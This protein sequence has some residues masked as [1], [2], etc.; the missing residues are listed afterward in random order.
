MGTVVEKIVTEVCLITKLVAFGRYICVKN[1]LI[2][3]SLQSLSH[4]EKASRQSE[5]TG[6][7]KS[8]R[9]FASDVQRLSLESLRTALGDR[10]SFMDT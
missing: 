4:E 1:R 2:F 10:V 3:F 8:L 6:G 7:E 9:L 5:G